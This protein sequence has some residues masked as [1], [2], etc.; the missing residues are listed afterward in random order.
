MRLALDQRRLSK[1]IAVEMEKVESDQDNLGRL[2]LQ[3]V[4]K[5]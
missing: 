5:N 1:I 4:L 3:L 2:C